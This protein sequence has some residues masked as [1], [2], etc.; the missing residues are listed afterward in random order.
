MRMFKELGI[1]VLLFVSLVAMVFSIDLALDQGYQ[2][3]VNNLRSPF[4][5]MS[6]A[7]Y[8]ILFLFLFV[9]LGSQ[10]LSVWGKKKKG[11]HGKTAKKGMN[12]NP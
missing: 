4:Q 1:T 3:A 6:G 12:G 7:E 2:T 9:L 10:I 8:C 5:V 11:Q